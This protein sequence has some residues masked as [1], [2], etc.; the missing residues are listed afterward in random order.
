MV[1]DIVRRT[2]ERENLIQKGDKILVALSGGPDSV[3]LLH[4][5]KKLEHIYDLKIYAA[6][7]NHMI[8]G[9]EAQKDAMYTAKLCDAFD[10]IFFVKSVDVPLY[11]KK[12]RLSLEEAARKVRYEMLFEIKDKISADKIAV[13]HNLDDQVETVLMRLMRGTGIHGLRGMDYLRE[14]GLIRP[15]LDVQKRDILK[16]CEEQKLSPRVDKTN[17]ET[18]YTRNRIRINLIP[19]IEAEY[20]PQIKMH[21][22]KMA[23]LLREDDAFLEAES[24]GIF[25]RDAVILEDR[26]KLQADDLSLLHPAIAKRIIRYAVK[27]AAGT[28]EGLESGHID[29]VIDLM[30]SPKTHAMLHLPKGVFVYKRPEGILFTKKTIEA[31][32]AEY[33]YSLKPGETIRIPEMDLKMESR[34]MSKEK[35]MMLPTG[36][37][38]KAFDIDKIQG[39][40]IVRSRRDGDRIRPM[41]MG[42]TK[43]LKDLFIDLKIPREKRDSIPILCDERGI[44]W[45]VG[46]KISEDY[47]IDENTKNVLRISCSERRVS[48]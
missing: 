11:A 44:L 34:T 7:L 18:E 6:H 16:Y 20:S 28:L 1:A 39:E 24:S 36:P 10:L 23:N 47:K 15:L 8:R 45:V 17:E 46:Y 4:C 29:D 19:L 21:L 13:A 14:D 12:E 33:R 48:L 37:L 2:I 31:V 35:C 40:L 30:K 26:V 43:K 41:G 27:E 3:C 42:G 38:T 5:L 9:M 32:S 25:Q 22:S